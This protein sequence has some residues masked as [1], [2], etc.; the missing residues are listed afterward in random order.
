MGVVAERSGEDTIAVA[1]FVMAV[2]M[3]VLHGFF[4]VRSGRVDLTTAAQPVTAG[5]L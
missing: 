5:A 4:T 2:T 1:V 3:A